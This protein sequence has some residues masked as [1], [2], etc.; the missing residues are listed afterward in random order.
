MC[1]TG[2]GHRRRGSDS[3]RAEDEA[4][5]PFGPGYIYMCVCVCV[6]VCVCAEGQYVYVYV[7]MIHV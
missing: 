4:R 3:A 1:V 6:C 5:T 7:C 2:R